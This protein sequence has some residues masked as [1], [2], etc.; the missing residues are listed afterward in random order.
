MT[1]YFIEEFLSYSISLYSILWTFLDN[2]FIANVM[3][4]ESSINTGLYEQLF[5]ELAIC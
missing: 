5:N 4:E 2:F 1:A 3:A